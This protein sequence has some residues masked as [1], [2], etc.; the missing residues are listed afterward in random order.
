MA[1]KLDQDAW[2]F[3]CELYALPGVKAACIALQERLG[4]SVT[5]LLT[6]IWAGETGRGAIGPEAL[7]AALESVHLWHGEV[8]RS[9]RQVR[10]Q[11]GPAS[12][13]VSTQHQELKDMVQHAELEAERLEQQVLLRDLALPAE[14]VESG[15]W[16]DAVCNAAAYVRRFAPEPEPQSISE[17]GLILS[18]ALPDP[19]GPH[20]TAV[21]AR[22]WTEG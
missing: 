5:T 2:T 1:E 6:L 12:D 17:L 9:L 3:I 11:L 20:L 15:D 16:P 4:L 19:D 8:T 13:E 10:R 14:A 22:Y 21:L 18:A 7:D